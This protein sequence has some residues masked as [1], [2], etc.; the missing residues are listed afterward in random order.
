MSKRTEKVESV[1]QHEVALALA[2]FLPR[3][4]LVTVTGVEVSPDLKQATVWIGTLSDNGEEVMQQIAEV[5]RDVQQSVNRRM[6]TKFVPRLH[7]QLDHGGEYAEQ[8]SR[9]LKNL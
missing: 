2:E 5:R 1:V 3:T 7:F 9:V 4:S 6:T 8:I